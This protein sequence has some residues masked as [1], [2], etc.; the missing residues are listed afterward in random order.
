MQIQQVEKS[1]RSEQ[2]RFEKKTGDRTRS[3]FFSEQ[4]IEP[5]RSAE[6]HGDPGKFSV[7]EGEVKHPGQCEQDGNELPAGQTLAQKNRAQKNVD[8]RRHEISQA[9]FD[10]AADIHGPNEK[11]PVDRKRESA[12]DAIEQGAP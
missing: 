10:D 7:T 9:G 2:R 12:G 1:N 11:E 6:D 3:G 5:K 4:A 8:Q